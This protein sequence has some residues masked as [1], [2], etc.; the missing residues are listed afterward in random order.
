MHVCFDN[1]KYINYLVIH[2]VKLKKKSYKNIKIR[3]FDENYIEEV[4]NIKIK[5]DKIIEILN[6]NNVFKETITKLNLKRAIIQLESTDYNFDATMYC[7]NQLKDNIAV[8]HLT[9]G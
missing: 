3:F 5:D 1:D 7:H 4:K 9:G 8:D 6:L 2:N